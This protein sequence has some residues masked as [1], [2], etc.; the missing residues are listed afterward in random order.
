[1][2]GE[3]ML[4]TREGGRRSFGFREFE[5]L[6]DLLGV[7]CAVML[8]NAMLHDAI[9][10]L[11]VVCESPFT[12]KAIRRSSACRKRISLA[13]R[14][15]QCNSHSQRNTLSQDDFTCFS[16]SSDSFSSFGASTL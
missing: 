9:F 8:R 12:T 11:D 13:F 7:C 3:K 14:L 2:K 10:L 4:R 16:A 1:M 15:L 6:V 5:T